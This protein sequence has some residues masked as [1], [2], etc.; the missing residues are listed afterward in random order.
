MALMAL[1]SLY[2]GQVPAELAPPEAPKDVVK[3]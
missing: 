3:G 2:A 1:G